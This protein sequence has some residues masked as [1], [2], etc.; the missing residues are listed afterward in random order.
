MQAASSSPNDSRSCAARSVARQ[1][2][3]GQRDPRSTRAAGRRPHVAALLLGAADDADRMPGSNGAATSD[4]MAGAEH[5]ADELDL[6]RSSTSHDSLFAAAF[7]QAL[8]GRLESP[9]STPRPEADADA[10][11]EVFARFVEQED[12][13]ECRRRHLADLLESEGRSPQRKCDS[14]AFVTRRASEHPQLLFG[15]RPEVTT[16]QPPCAS[17]SGSA[18]NGVPSRPPRGGAHE[19]LR[20]VPGE[21]ARR[22]NAGRAAAFHVEQLEP[23]RWCHRRRDSS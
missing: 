17:Q 3:D 21:R 12:R 15:H 20:L 13:G 23:R 6:I 7:W 16:T 5:G 1:M 19:E 10:Q 14:A 4:L 22:A 8:A 9:G 18:W 2:V 11:H